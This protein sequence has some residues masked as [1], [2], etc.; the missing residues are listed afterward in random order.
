MINQFLLRAAS[1]AV[2]ASLLAGT[3][4]ANSCYGRSIGDSVCCG[5]TADGTGIYTCDYGYSCASGYECR[6]NLGAGDIVGMIVG[7]LVFMFAVAACVYFCRSRGYCG[8]ERRMMV[9]ASSPLV[10]GQPVY[11]QPVAYHTY[12]AQPGSPCQQAYHHQNNTNLYGQQQP[13][14]QQQAYPAF[15]R[16]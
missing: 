4:A 3:A 11:G 10:A 14:P 8:G 15:Q 12:P 2:T 6:R 16:V 9:V 13:P 5:R 7:I 1:A